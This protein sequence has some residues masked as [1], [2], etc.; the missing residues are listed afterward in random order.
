MSERS[1]PG[2]YVVLVLLKIYIWKLRLDSCKDL[3]RNQAALMRSN[4]MLD[5]SP[6]HLL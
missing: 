3:Q 1:T 5:T 6:S 4:I 2:I